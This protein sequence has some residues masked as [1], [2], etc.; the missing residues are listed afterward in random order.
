[1]VKNNANLCTFN[2]DSP[3]DTCSN[4]NEIFC[5]HDDN[6]VIVSHLLEQS[7]IL[8]SL[9]GVLISSLILETIWIFIIYLIYVLLFFLVIQSRITCSHCPYY[10]EDRRFLHCSENHFTPKLWR[11]H[12]EPITRW[13]QA[14]T[15]VGFGVLGGFPL[16]IELLAVWVFYQTSTDAI[17]LLAIL[18]VFLGTLFTLAV[19]YVT[20][21]FL[22]CPH[23]LN[24]S[25][26]LNKVPEKNV[27]EY[28]QRNPVMRNAWEKHRKQQLKKQQ[29]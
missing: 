3:C 20:F 14:G 4:K 24:F 28:L 9:F 13:E 21:F 7:F 8:M 27:N 12:P 26:I 25:C 2:P 6:K 23:C 5:K 19:F 10:A 29:Y 11:Y 1:M 15:I 18:G 22:Y 16:I 17:S